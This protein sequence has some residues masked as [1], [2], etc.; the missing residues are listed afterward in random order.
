MFTNYNLDYDDLIKSLELSESDVKS[1]FKYI[2]KEKLNEDFE[3]I[4]SESRQTDEL[5]DEVMDY[6][7]TGQILEPN[8]ESSNDLLVFDTETMVDNVLLS[9]DNFIM[10]NNTNTA[11]KEYLHNLFDGL[12]TYVDSEVGEKNQVEPEQEFEDNYMDFDFSEDLIDDSE[13]NSEI[14]SQNTED[15]V[16]KFKTLDEKIEFLKSKLEDDGK[17]SEV[18]RNKD[19]S[20]SL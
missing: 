7:Y 3:T 5:E 1:L 11:Q 2:L 16:S 4:N 8:N 19:N 20:V 9:D 17:E 13:D 15:I 10:E 12:K 14:I 6:C 18:Y